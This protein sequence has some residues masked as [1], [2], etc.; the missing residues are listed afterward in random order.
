MKV[1]VLGAGITG[2][3]AAHR[4]RTLGAEPLVLESAAE[5]GGVMQSTRRDG[6]LVEHGPNSMMLPSLTVEDWLR[7]TGLA[8]T[9]TS[10]EPGA[11]KR[12]L[13]R[14]G[15]AHPLPSGPWSALTT[16]LFSLRGKLRVLAEPFIPRGMIDDEAL[17]S[18]VR[19]RLGA[20]VLAYAV[21]PFVAGIYAGDPEKL[22]VRQAFPK[23]WR[24]EHLHG[25]F[26]RGTFAVLRARKKSGNTFRPRMVSFREGMGSLP[27][28]VAEGLGSAVHTGCRL[29]SLR[30]R[31]SAWTVAWE[32]RD[33]TNHEST[34]AALLCT[35]PA[36]SVA[37]LPWPEE[38]VPGLAPIQA[39]PHARVAVVALGFPRT[40]VEHPLDGFGMLVPAVEGRRILG[41]LFSSSLFPGRAPAGQVLLTTFVGGERQPQ[42]AELPDEE[43]AATVLGDLRDLLGVHGAP[44]HRTIIRW[45]RG[46]PQYNVGLAVRAAGAADDLAKRFPGLHFAGSW[47]GGVAAG[48]CINNGL[49]AAARIVAGDPAEPA[50]SAPGR[51]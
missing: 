37:R 12:F 32:A 35:V 5:P 24:L 49:Q 6:F 18:M 33:G 16:P 45:P 23:L 51:L 21:E 31:E 34:A 19:R 13:V 17:A 30:R 50:G 47:L 1:I 9:V 11:A 2:L 22:S 3:A 46:I 25:S 36:H 43:L 44:V 27:R 15:R 41:T 38:L 7:E 48:Q 29:H 10:P 40:A 14:D 4:L 42:L 20:E 26:I 28:R 39:I 8:E